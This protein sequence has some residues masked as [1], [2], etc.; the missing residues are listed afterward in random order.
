MDTGS[1]P[2]FPIYPG[3]PDANAATAWI[4][5]VGMG[6]DRW[7]LAAAAIGTAASK[8]VPITI[9]TVEYYNRIASPDG[10]VADWN[11]APVL[12]TTSVSSSSTTPPSA[13]PGPTCSGLCHLARRAELKWKSAKVLDVVD[14]IDLVA[15]AATGR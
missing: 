10:G 11:Y 2:G 12:P 5:Q 4:P 15:G 1:I 13:I 3:D 8:A 6:F 14:F 7:M 9:D